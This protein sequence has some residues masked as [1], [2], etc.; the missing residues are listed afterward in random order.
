MRCSGISGR[1]NTISN[2]GLLVVEPGE[3]TVEGDEAGRS[4]DDDM[5]RMK[6]TRRL[7]K[8]IACFVLAFARW[9]L[10]GA[11]RKGVSEL[12]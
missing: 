10:F 4:S 11:M 8:K 2:L 3:Q 7:Q 1:S 9:L 12:N 5:P 6:L